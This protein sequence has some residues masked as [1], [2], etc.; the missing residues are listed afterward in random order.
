MQIICVKDLKPYNCIQI[1][2]D[3]QIR[4][5]TWNLIVSEL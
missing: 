3:Y 2:D 1:N 4:M 5:V